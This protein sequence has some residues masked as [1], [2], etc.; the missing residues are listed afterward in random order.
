MKKI[1]LA[2]VVFSTF[3]FAT[4]WVCY[5][6]VNGEPT[7]G[8]IK[9]TAQSKQEAHKKA[10]TKYKDLGYKIDSVNCK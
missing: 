9:V 10:M 5:R 8:F 3:S 2:G 4:E 1:I 7:G 6:Y